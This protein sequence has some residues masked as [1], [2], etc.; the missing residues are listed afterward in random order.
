MTK[1][2]PRRRNH[3]KHEYEHSLQ[4]ARDGGDPRDTHKNELRLRL[5]AAGRKAIDDLRNSGAICDMAYRRAEAELD[6]VEISARMVRRIERGNGA[7]TQ[8]RTVDLLYYQVRCS[9]TELRQLK[10]ARAG[11]GGERG[12]NCHN[13]P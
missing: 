4:V 9:T 11:A 8:D 13:A 7:A 3:L 1:K 6:Q 2:T 12:G 5:V 10:L